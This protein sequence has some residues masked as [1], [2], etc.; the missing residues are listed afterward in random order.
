MLNKKSVLTVQIVLRVTY[1]P[2]L[3]VPMFADKNLDPFYMLQTSMETVNVHS[4]AV[5]RKGV[6]AGAN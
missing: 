1:Q 4:N 5:R 6:D 3:I 2:L